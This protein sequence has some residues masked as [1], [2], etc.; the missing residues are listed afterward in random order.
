MFRTG[1]HCRGVHHIV[2][3]VFVVCYLPLFCR[4]LDVLSFRLSIPQ[5]ERLLERKRSD[6]FVN[7]VLLC[8]QLCIQK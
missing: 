6:S 4:D 8:L 1:G 5:R 2:F 3:L 7:F